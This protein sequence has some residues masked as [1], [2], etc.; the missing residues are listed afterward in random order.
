[1]PLTSTKTPATPPE[2]L[3]PLV[4]MSPDLEGNA[5]VLMQRAKRALRDAGAGRLEIELFM[6]ECGAEVVTATPTDAVSREQWERVVDAVA[7]RCTIY[8]GD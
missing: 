6:H 7:K 1:M 3:R 5:F 4:A 2:L 8:W